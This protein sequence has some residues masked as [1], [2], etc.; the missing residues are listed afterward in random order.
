MQRLFI[1]VP[2]LFVIDS[3][4]CLS[5]AFGIDAEQAATLR[6][7]PAPGAVEP[8][9]FDVRLWW[10]SRVRGNVSAGEHPTQIVPGDVLD[11]RNDMGI[12]RGTLWE[13]TLAYNAGFFDRIS[14]H[15]I[16]GKF[17]GGKTL[18]KTI[19]FTMKR[20]H[21]DETWDT[22]VTVLMGELEYDHALLN[23]PSVTI[24]GG[25]GIGYYGFTYGFLAGNGVD[26]S[27]EDV[28]AVAPS[29]HAEASAGLAETLSFRIE[30]RYAFPGLEK[31][32]DGLGM[33]HFLSAQAALLWQVSPRVNAEA[34]LN[35][36]QARA[37]YAGKEVDNNYGD[38][39]IN[40][41]VNGP[42]LGVTLRF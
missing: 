16:Q 18:T 14:L 5:P 4:W 20:F 38:N 28:R 17:T 25:M 12:R 24:W 19:D 30:G 8:F 3:L 27:L 36:F 9:R 42:S 22:A 37:R 13:T 11:L 10:L 31:L 40:M 23:R 7:S 34:G 39:R 15:G 32:R 6:V 41:R 1:I 35:W 29:L 33:L 26:R 21:A 2:L